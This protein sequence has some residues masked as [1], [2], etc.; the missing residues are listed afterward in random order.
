MGC[1]GR[2]GELELDSIGIGARCCLAGSDGLQ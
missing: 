2:E 1:R